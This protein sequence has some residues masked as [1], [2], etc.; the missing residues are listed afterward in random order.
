MTGEQLMAY[1]NKL[2]QTS[3]NAAALS[4]KLN[5]ESNAIKEKKPRVTSEKQRKR[6]ALLDEL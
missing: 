4:A 5:N 1:V 3:G 6:Q 2:R